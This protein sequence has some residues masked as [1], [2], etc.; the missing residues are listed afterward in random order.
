[1]YNT[2]VP[3]R[4]DLPSSAQL[5]RSTVIASAIA[6]T[7]LVTVV[8][9]SEYAVDPTGI[10]G[11][12]G[13]TKMGEIKTG[14]AAEARAQELADAVSASA[15]P[16]QAQLDRLEQQIKT[17]N[18]AMQKLLEVNTIAMPAED[19]PAR[20]D[21]T[22]MNDRLA[23]APQ[24]DADAMASDPVA[25]L[26]SAEPSAELSSPDPI[27]TAAVPEGRQDNMEFTLN[28]GEGAEV[29]LKM[30]NGEQAQYSWSANGG[31]LNFEVHGEGAGDKKKSY[32]KGRM[33]PEYEGSIQAAFDGQ[34]GWFW[35]NRTETPVTL[36]LRTGGAYSDII[37]VR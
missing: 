35:R 9:P 23:M 30:L 31:R 33:A 11:L 24:I 34:H 5:L 14:L 15:S 1:M 4:S 16:N 32:D 17:L 10:G 37:R 27:N 25:E 6:V 2:K 28:P 22:L 18:V 29:K 36:T 21:P 26:A 12:L 8:M 3:A 7:A 19:Y 20:L 13:L